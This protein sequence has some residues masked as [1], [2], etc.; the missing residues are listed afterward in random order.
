M[1]LKIEIKNFCKKYNLK[2]EDFNESNNILVTS[3]ICKT[4]K[5]KDNVNF[6]K[7]KGEEYK[8]RFF[9][10]HTII[11]YGNYVDFVTLHHE[12]TPLNYTSTILTANMIN[13]LKSLSL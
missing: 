9:E 1:E 13:Y 3:K 6:I 5:Y 8:C 10:Y 12:K 11:N 7:G 4:K 2:F